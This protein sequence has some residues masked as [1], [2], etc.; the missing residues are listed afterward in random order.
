MRLRRDEIDASQRDAAFRILSYFQPSPTKTAAP[1]AS[2]YRLRSAVP[3][4]SLASDLALLEIA[5]IK[6]APL[7]PC[8]YPFVERLIGTVR[9]EYL[10]HLWFWNQ[11][12]L[13]RKLA[14]FAR[15]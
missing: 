7:V 9:R 5:N 3:I 14:R 11:L 12:D 6:T 13:H 4:P 15:Y 2:E 1:E 10:D 8:S